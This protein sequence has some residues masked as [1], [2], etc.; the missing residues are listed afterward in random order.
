M[1]TGNVPAL[2]QG[3]EAQRMASEKV[4]REEREDIERGKRERKDD[5]RKANAKYNY[6]VEPSS[7]TGCLSEAIWLSVKKTSTK[8]DWRHYARL[9]GGRSIFR[10]WASPWIKRAPRKGGQYIGLVY[11]SKEDVFD[12]AD[13]IGQNSYRRN[14]FQRPT[15]REVHMTPFLCKQE[16]SPQDDQAQ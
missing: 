4:W 11:R 14:H 10:G 12:M 15:A 8:T 1:S 5:I 13:R 6:F 2:P 3:T 7:R 16:R 9:N